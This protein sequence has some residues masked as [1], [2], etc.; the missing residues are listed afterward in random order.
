[1]MR[2]SLLIFHCFVLCLA[3]VACS[4]TNSVY[5]EELKKDEYLKSNFPAK[6]RGENPGTP[7]ETNFDR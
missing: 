2:S 4:S 6:K 3:L 7:V 5:D 1:M